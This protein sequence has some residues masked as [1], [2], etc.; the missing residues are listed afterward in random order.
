[1]SSIIVT[2]A[3]SRGL[4]DLEGAIR[5]AAGGHTFEAVTRDQLTVIE[6]QL[7][8]IIDAPFR[9]ALMYFREGNLDKTKD[10]LIE[11]ISLNELD[12][13]ANA[14]YCTLLAATNPTLA[15]QYQE[16]ILR[17]FGPH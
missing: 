14:L 17:K 8:S 3:L 15:L 11:A 6:K 1:M 10:K 12:L 16:E 13:P 5:T 7:D 2:W 4:T 9:Q